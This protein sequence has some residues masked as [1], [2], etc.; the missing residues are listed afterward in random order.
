MREENE[1]LHGRLAV[2]EERLGKMEKDISKAQLLQ[3][4]GLVDE[5][6]FSR[7]L[8]EAVLSAERYARFLCLVLVG[9]PE[10]DR[11]M[12]RENVALETAARLREALRKT[13]L[14]ALYETGDV[15]VLL[16][17]AEVSQG[18]QALKRVQEEIGDVATP[19]YSMACYPSDAHK[20]DVLLDLLTERLAKLQNSHRPGPVVNFGES[21]LELS[22]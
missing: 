12:S 7:R 6:Y 9:V 17:E 19:L 1:R 13:D 5:R 16:E 4:Q 21:T 2:L 22:N 11:D 3:H 14:V 20:E 15:Y 18:L 10:R 8:R